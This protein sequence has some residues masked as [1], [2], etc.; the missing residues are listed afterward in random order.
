MHE[1]SLATGILELVEGAAAREG[2]A[3]V[4]AL[5][6]E[7][8]KL[9]GVELA[10]LRF[11][12]EAAARGTCLEG[13]RIEVDEPPGLAWCM[14]CADNVEIQARGDPCPRC[15]GWQLVARGGDRLRVVDLQVID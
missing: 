4:T 1:M 3:R 2:F 9:A 13:A 12:L 10:A 5:R 15:G 7:C 8:G 11:A 6:L 14:P